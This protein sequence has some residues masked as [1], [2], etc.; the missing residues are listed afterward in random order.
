[1]ATIDYI[2]YVHGRKNGKWDVTAV[3][4]DGFP[5]RV[6]LRASLARS[7]ISRQ[8]QRDIDAPMYEIERTGPRLRLVKPGQKLHKTLPFR[9]VWWSGFPQPTQE[10]EDLSS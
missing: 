9:W 4:E 1:M 6:Y 7:V 8:K 3:Y 2:T 10:H 5:N